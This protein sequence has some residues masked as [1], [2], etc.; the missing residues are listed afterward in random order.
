MTGHN[1][2]PTVVVSNFAEAH[3]DFLGRA[4]DKGERDG[5]IHSE[6]AHADRTLLWCGDPKLV[7]VSFPIAHSDW[8]TGRLGYSNT[9]YLSPEN[10]TSFLSNDIM[11]ED[12]LLQGLLD[13]AGPDRTLQLIPYATTPEFLDLVDLLRDDHNLIVLLPESPDR[14][15]LWLRDYVDTK[16]GFRLLASTCLSDADRLIP[17][18]IPCYSLEEAA[19][20]ASW[21]NKRGETCV[22]KADTGESG[23]GFNVFRPEDNLTKA[24]LLA[25]LKDNT[26][27]ANE[28]VVVEE[29]IHSPNNLS[30]SPEVFVPPP[31]D[32]EP[33]IMYM[34][35]QVLENFGDFFGIEVNKSLY[36]QA[37]YPDLERSSLAIARQLQKM[38]YVGHFD[39]DCLVD[40]N[41][42]L[43]LLEVN[44]R[45]TGGTHVHDFAV[46]VI[47]EDY[48][49]KVA[50]LSY[51]A[52]N[53]GKINNA[54][55]LMSA[56]KDFLYPMGGDPTRGIV[57]TITTPIVDHYFGSIVVAPTQLE[58]RALQAKI[59]EYLANY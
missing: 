23:I 2:I 1:Q 27:F 49:D 46:H 9:S 33:Y 15:H 8:I 43:R 41:G 17:F 28:P 50:L 21:F 4:A 19:L 36:E 10:P 12:A 18:G 29:Y 38:G 30:P 52:M 16:V 40:E 22:V 42:G 32:G 54:A 3:V 26:F 34:T 20:V 14:D 5:L 6:S 53:S 57:V 51:E 13:Y 59:Q 24:D 7:Y 37:W 55:E 44:A 58:A 25:F 56:L 47:G 31:E 48:I 35:T 11:R 39:L 45:R